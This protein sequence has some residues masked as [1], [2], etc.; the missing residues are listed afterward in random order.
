MIE[1]DTD[2]LLASAA[3][4]IERRD[5]EILLAHAWGLTRAQ[6]LAR[7]GGAVPAEVTARFNASCGQR[8]AGVPVAYLLGQREF[9]SLAFEVSPAV[10]VPRPETELLVERVLQQVQAPVAEVVDLGTGSGAIAVAIA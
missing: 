10:L 4:E 7:T 8:A 2:R 3:R 6:L 1:A 5:V 9:W